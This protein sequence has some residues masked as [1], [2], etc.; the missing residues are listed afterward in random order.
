MSKGSIH[1][2]FYCNDADY[3]IFGNWKKIGNPHFSYF[4]YQK[5]NI[6]MIS[7]ETF[8]NFFHTFDCQYR[9]VE[10]LYKALGLK[11]SMFDANIPL[12]RILD[13]LAGDIAMAVYCDV[14]PAQYLLT[15]CDVVSDAL[16]HFVWAGYTNASK[17]IMVT[18]D[19]TGEELRFTPMD[20]NDL[21]RFYD[22]ITSTDFYHTVCGLKDGLLSAIEWEIKGD[23]EY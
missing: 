11:D 18:K 17:V 10:D 15:Y 3:Q 23:V 20:S 16:Y 13:Y 7:K 14:Q 8:I 12:V 2:V 5:E 9:A 1:S 21:G 22:F 19:E 4:I 6:I